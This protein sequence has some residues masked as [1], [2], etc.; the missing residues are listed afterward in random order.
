[1]SFFYGAGGLTVIFVCAFPYDPIRLW[2]NL[3]SDL[4][5]IPVMGRTTSPSHHSTSKRGLTGVGVSMQMGH[6]VGRDMSW[7]WYLDDNTSGD[8]ICC[9]GSLSCDRSSVGS[10]SSS[11]C[12]SI[13]T[14]I[15][16]ICRSTRQCQE[17]EIEY[18]LPGGCLRVA[19]APMAWKPRAS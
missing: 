15:Q 1:M 5:N 13:Q 6:P 7:W 14:V 10:S 17:H 8:V 2:E 9:N 19:T 4:S 3:K 12:P 11:S 18:Q 16:V